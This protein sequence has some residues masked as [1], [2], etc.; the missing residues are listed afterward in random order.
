M[1]KGLVERGVI[2]IFVILVC[3]SVL[4]NIAEAKT[5]GSYDYNEK[6][7]IFENDSFSKNTSYIINITLLGYSGP[8]S[9]TDDGRLELERDVFDSSI[10]ITI[11]G[12]NFSDDLTVTPPK[13]PAPK[14]TTPISNESD[15]TTLAPATTEPPKDKPV[16]LKQLLINLAAVLLGLAGVI[17][18]LFKL[19]ILRL[20]KDEEPRRLSQVPEQTIETNYKLILEL[21]DGTER[22]PDRT[23]EITDKNGILIA[24]GKS[25]ING[26]FRFELPKDTYMVNIKGGENYEDYSK[27]VKL[28]DDNRVSLTL[29]KKQHLQIEVVDESGKPIKGISVRVTESGEGMDAP[30]NPE[31]DANG[32]ARFTLSRKKKY[33]ASIN[34]MTQDYSIPGSIEITSSDTVKKFTLKRKEGMLEITVTEQGKGQNFAGIPFT[35]VKKGT[36]NILEFISD[37]NGMIK[38]KVLIGDYTIKIKPGAS[39]LYDASEKLVNVPENIL[40]PVTLD[41]R[42]SYKPNNQTITAI[43]KHYEKLNNSFKEVSA[44]DKCIP[45]FFKSTGE[46]PL[47][48]IERIIKRPVEFL[49]SK[50]TPDEIINHILSAEEI[51]SEE[52]SRIMR[53]KSNVDFYYSIQNL[54]QVEELAVSDYSQEKFNELVHD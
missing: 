49:G 32:I 4:I 38:Q 36:N 15:N 28:S 7:L 26:K 39:Q 54:P 18:A 43:N 11:R 22:I 20:K 16:D 30:G 3:A 34:A 25:D 42:F 5:K 14:A 52:I 45:L 50:T 37:S 10:G 47:K 1:R 31:T 48:L 44:Y 23:I 27:K 17:F 21:D 9:K 46:R 35:V 13:K 53:E 33:K 40:V 12:D 29:L 24:N 8:P 2:V 41:L 6:K 51:I 19:G